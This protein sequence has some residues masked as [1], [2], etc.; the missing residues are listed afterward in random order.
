MNNRNPR[1]GNLVPVIHKLRRLNMI[2]VVLTEGPCDN[3]IPIGIVE[4]NSVHHIP[5]ALKR[6]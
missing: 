6:Q 1:W 4:G 3:F 2:A 5:M